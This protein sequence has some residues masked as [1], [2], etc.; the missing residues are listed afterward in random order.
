MGEHGRPNAASNAGLVS[1]CLLVEN[2]LKLEEKKRGSGNPN[3]ATI[4]E[5]FDLRWAAWRINKKIFP[6]REWFS[7]KKEAEQ[8]HKSQEREVDRRNPFRSEIRV[9]LCTQR[10]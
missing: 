2:D 9:R 4:R 7:E 5:W 6:R 10:K 3:D 1:D 8:N